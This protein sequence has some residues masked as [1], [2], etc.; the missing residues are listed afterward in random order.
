ML[1][2]RLGLLVAAL[3]TRATPARGD[4]IDDLVAAVS[5]AN[6]QSHI[7]T[8]AAAPRDTPLAKADAAAYVTTELASYGYTVT[9][10]PVGPTDNL[11]ATLPGTRTPDR[12]FIVGAHYDSVA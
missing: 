9:T 3:L 11:I 2:G 1:L 6:I 12:A 5:Q 4:A 8:L 7:E 10:D